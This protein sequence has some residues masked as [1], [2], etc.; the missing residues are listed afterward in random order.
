MAK[1]AISY[2]RGDN[3]ACRRSEISAYLLL[4]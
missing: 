3:V 1:Q 4:F 2:F